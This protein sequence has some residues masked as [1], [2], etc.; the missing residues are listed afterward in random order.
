MA[1]SLFALLDDIAVL[2]RAAASSVDD[3]AAAAGRA[4]SKAAGVVI[5]DA[6]VTPQYVQSISPKRELPVVWRIARGSL[7][8]KAAII[9][10]IMVLSAWAPGVFPWL[11]LAGGTYLAYEGAERVWHWLHRRHAP[12]ASA[13]EVLERPAADEDKIVASAVRTDLVLSTEIMLISLASID[14]DGWVM[15]LAV[16]VVVAVVMTLAVYGAVALLIRMDDVG[17]WLTRRSAAL[18]RTIG[19]GLVRA[20]PKVFSLITVVGVVAML[21]VGGHILVTNLAEVGWAGPHHVVVAATEAVG[22]PG[23]LTWVIDSALSAVAGLVWGAVIVVVVGAI[24]RLRRRR[25]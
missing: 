19:A 18:A 21:W 17:L 8:N 24:G 12:K 25:A 5:D 23:A 10:V 4:S 7:L 6:A 22:G 2:A 16:L 20:M 14:V 9:V 15:R 13:T 11:L 3:V 1:A